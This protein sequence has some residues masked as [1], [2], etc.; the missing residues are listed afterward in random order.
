MRQNTLSESEIITQAREAFG[1]EVFGNSP[2]RSDLEDALE[3]F[4]MNGTS[5]G[6]GGD[7]DHDH[8]FYRVHRWIVVTNS[9]G[10]HTIETYDSEQEA[11]DAFENHEREE[12]EW[13]DT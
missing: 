13:L 10:F 2:H 4:Y 3:S 6:S 8:H 7:V 12:S 5:D 9:Q 1:D 11:I